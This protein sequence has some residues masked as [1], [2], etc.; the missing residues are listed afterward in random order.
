MSAN[1]IHLESLAQLLSEKIV[2]FVV[3]QTLKRAYAFIEVRRYE[4]PANNNKKQR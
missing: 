1:T 4:Q 3:A 2:P